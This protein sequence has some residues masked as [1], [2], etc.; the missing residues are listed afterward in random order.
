MSGRKSEQ[1]NGNW[2]E[3]SAWMLATM[4]LLIVA[5][6]KDFLT[7]EVDY[8]EKA[9][10]ETSAASVPYDDAS[11]IADLAYEGA[12]N[13][14][15][16]DVLTCANIT[17]DTLTASMHRVTVDFGT[18]CTDGNGN[19][20]SGIIRTTYS[21]PRTMGGATTDIEFINYYYNQ[22]RIEGYYHQ[23]YL[24]LNTANQPEWAVDIEGSAVYSP[25]DTLHYRSAR[26]RRWADGFIPFNPSAIKIEIEGSAFG[27][28]TGRPSWL[29]TT[30]EPLV[31]VLNCAYIVDG[32]YEVSVTGR[33]NFLVDFGNGN[34]DNQAE[35]SDGNST[36]IVQI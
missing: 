2:L 5:C 16:S 21:L 22:V 8:D 34:C 3:R 23:S 9:A 18:G 25:G 33:A 17:I 28:R 30:T 13:G 26:T 29:A 35:V 4:A 1:T 27:E 7:G 32:T 15:M 24:G 19:T 36:A 12:Y 14:K 20:R 10:A 11:V 6:E 31:W